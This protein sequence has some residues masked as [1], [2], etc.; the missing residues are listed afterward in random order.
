MKRLS[1]KIFGYT[2]YMEVSKPKKAIISK[3]MGAVPKP[4]KLNFGPGPNWRKPDN[5]WLSVDIDP[6]LGEIVVDFQKFVNLPIPDGSVSCVYGSHVFE[7]MSI[8]K[9]PL[10]FKE[11]F[12]VLQPGGIVRLIL[13]DAGKSVH[14]Y[15]KNNKDFLLFKRRRER[16]K[17]F[18]GIDYT[19]FECMR[20]DYLS[21]AGQVGL[22]GNDALAHQN[23]WDEETIKADLTRAGFDPAKIQRM[24][25]QKSQSE[26]FGFEGTYPSEANEDYRSLYIEAIK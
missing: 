3:D 20:E 11:I 15:V 18:S 16:A 8:F 25:F 6:D 14:E 1:T 17:E 13:P 10:I 12:R 24:D 23:A 26:D 5:H 19:L 7:H 2:L 9:T 22:L 21:K 4:Y